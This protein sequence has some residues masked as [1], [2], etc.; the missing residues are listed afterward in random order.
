MHNTRGARRQ[1]RCTIRTCLRLSGPL[2]R[3]STL[4][5]GGE[6]TGARTRELYPCPRQR[7]GSAHTR[8]PRQRPPHPAPVAQWIEQ[9]PSKR[10]AAGSSP[11]GGAHS[12]P[13]SGRAFLLVRRHPGARQK[14][15]EPLPSPRVGFRGCTAVSGFLRVAVS[16]TCRSF[17]RPSGHLRS[18]SERVGALL[19]GRLRQIPSGFEPPF[20]VRKLPVDPPGISGEQ[21]GHA[22]AGPLG[23]LS[24]RYAVIEPLGETRMAVVVDPLA[25]R[26]VEDVRGQHGLPS[27]APSA[28][29]DG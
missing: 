4:S 17:R 28:T 1:K 26:R 5:H 21:H 25:G 23:D 9:A 2:H 7:H 12:P 11:A 13:S 18:S 14:A 29:D 3:T 6:A 16:N 19:F 10:L 15:P 27:A 22:V 20:Q 24:G 8:A